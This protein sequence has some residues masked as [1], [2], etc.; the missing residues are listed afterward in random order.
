MKENKT[1]NSQQAKRIEL[2]LEVK[3]D[4]YQGKD[5]KTYETVVAELVDPFPEYVEDFNHKRIAPRW[6]R[7][8]AVFR[9]R[10][11]RQ[12][13]TSDNVI[14]KGYCE[15]VGFVSKKPEDNGKTVY[16]PGIFVTAPYSG[17]DVEFAF[18]KNKITEG[19]KIT[20]S[21]SSDSYVFRDLVSE[22]WGGSYEPAESVVSGEDAE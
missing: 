8:A 10:M 18:K 3:L 9:F 5:G 16:Y 6:D 19:G 15:P 7:D 22:Q 20:Y 2:K 4:S 21:E 14:L 1:K 17:E 11:K 12:L 13:R